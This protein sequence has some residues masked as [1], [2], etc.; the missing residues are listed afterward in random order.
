M[1]TELEAKLLGKQML[2]DLDNNPFWVIYTWENIGWHVCLKN[3]YANSVMHANVY[4]DG[5]IKY[6]VMSSV[7]GPNGSDEIFWHEPECSTPKEAIAKKIECMKKFVTD[8][9]LVYEKLESSSTFKG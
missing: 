1:K 7:D 4:P 8:A 2:D 9:G 5:S 6:D 3:Q